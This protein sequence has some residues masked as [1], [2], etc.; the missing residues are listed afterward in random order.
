L[1]DDSKDLRMLPTVNAARFLERLDKVLKDNNP[2]SFYKLPAPGTW[3][4]FAPG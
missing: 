1:P 4:R 2:S 3:L